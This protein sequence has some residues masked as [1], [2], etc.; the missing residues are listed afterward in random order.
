[1]LSNELKLHSWP[2]EKMPIAFLAHHAPAATAHFLASD[3]EIPLLVGV[4][5]HCQ[6][7]LARS[8]KPPAYTNDAAYCR[9]SPALRQSG[10]SC[11]I[12][13]AAPFPPYILA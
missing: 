10:S 4:D 11:S 7:R 3:D 8:A 2:R 1:M 9:Q 5:V 12:G 13:G 6:G